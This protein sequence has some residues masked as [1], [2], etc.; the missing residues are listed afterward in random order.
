MIRVAS[1]APAAA[2]AAMAL[3]TVGSGSPPL[4]TRP[5]LGAAGFRDSLEAVLTISG[6]ASGETG[7]EVLVD[8]DERIYIAGSHGG[9]DTDGDGQVDRPADGIDPMWLR[10]GR[11]GMVQWLA[12]AMAPGFDQARS[13]ALDRA[14]GAYGVGSVREGDMVV[15][16]SQTLRRSGGRDGYL[17]RFGDTGWMLWSRQTSGPG[18]ESISDV[19]SDREGN[20][21]VVGFGEGSFRLEGL[22]EPIEATGSRATFIASY[23][24]EGAARWVRTWPDGEGW[25]WNHVSVGP[26]GDLWAVGRHDPV[27]VDLDGDGRRELRRAGGFGQFIARFDATGELRNAWQVSPI[28]VGERIGASI[29]DL[30][31][32][33][34]GD[35]IVG[36]SLVGGVDFDGDGRADARSRRPNEPDGYAARYAPDG[37]LRWARTH[38]I[39]GVW[40]V[41]TDGRRIA[42]AGFYEGRRDLNQ[43]GRIDEDDRLGEEPDAGSLGSEIL[44]L[45]LDRD[46]RLEQHITAPGIGGD[47]ARSVAFVPEESA[48]WVTGFFK[49]AA[50]FD[51]PPMEEG[52]GYIRCDALGD[53]F[54]ARYR[55]A[56]ALERREIVLTV[57]PWSD[58][59]RRGGHLQWSGAASSSIEI[60]RDGVLI[61]TTA[62]DGDHRDGLP[63]GVSGPFEYQVC[64]TGTGVC[65]KRVSLAF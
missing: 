50:D 49:L 35:V 53:I 21:Y 24:A 47:Q 11:D 57:D 13:I 19:A 51:G 16:A 55:L 37:T 42:L 27:G 3:G 8:E 12:S 65:S 59:P 28:G 6:P 62:N 1:V 44:V 29:V 9:F 31:F 60:Y 4:D 33:D 10:A 43:D 61:E 26:A 7:W 38:V 25:L 39:D 5:A 56:P 17:A 54:W 20:A 63:S 34:D 30:V 41:A 36:G 48:I 52:R 22:E 14:G 18:D 32:A 23:D 40:D 46:G 45:V 58:G 64:E 2:V 15:N